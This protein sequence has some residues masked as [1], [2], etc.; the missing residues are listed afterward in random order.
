M[1]MARSAIVFGLAVL[2]GFVLQLAERAMAEP[3]ATKDNGKDA[4]GW[5]ALFDKK[6][7]DGWKSADYYGAGKVQVKDEA[8][9]LEKGKKM[10][11]V[12]YGR[13]DFPKMD[14]EVA[15]EARK[16]AG[17]DFFGTTTFP[18]GDAFCSL[19]L[20]GWGG[21]VVGLS[22]IDSADASENETRKE[23]SFKDGQW[24]KVR[25]RVSSKR[26]EAWID[27]DKVVDLDTTDRRIS[28]RVECQACKP[29]GIAT[30][31]TT[32]AVRDIRVRALTAADKKAIAETKPEKKD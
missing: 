32:G 21:S 10:T 31:E 12:T 3:P 8:I 2:L 24:Y 29:F 9:L 15:L 6:S 25:I 22:S 23:V 17:D 5:K 27:R 4:A 14:Y 16:V 26:I 30:Y 20:G 18:V 13:N 19:V 11:G 28:I 1:S 7:L